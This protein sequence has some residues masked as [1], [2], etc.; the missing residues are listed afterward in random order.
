MKA[1]LAS[2]WHGAGQKYFGAFMETAKRHGIEPQNFDPE[3]WPGDTWQTKEWWRKSAG[4][5][6]FVKENADNYSHFLFTDSHDIVFAAG[7][8]EILAKFKALDS[9]IVFSS[10]C[11]PWPDTTQAPLYPETPHRTK[12]ANAGMWIATTEAAVLFTEELAT[13]AARKEKCDQGIIVDMFLSRRHPIKL[14]TACSLCF[15][16]N[17][18]SMSYLDLSGPRI[19]ATDTNETPVMFHGNA[20]ADLRA[21]IAKLDQP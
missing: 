15:C 6:R 18:D 11:Y 10:E 21:I 5:A 7:W 13:I 20:N 3:Q 4:Q 17:M 1:V 2:T 12:Y 14:D 19:R 16:C 9:L 8:E